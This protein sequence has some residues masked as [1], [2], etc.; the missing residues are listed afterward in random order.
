VQTQGEEVQKE[1]Q[2]TRKRGGQGWF[3]LCFVL[4]LFCL[5]LFASKQ[6]AASQ[7]SSDLLISDLRNPRFFLGLFLIISSDVRNLSSDL[8]MLISDLFLLF[9]RTQQGGKNPES[10]HFGDSFRAA[11]QTA[12]S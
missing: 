4:I 2:L 12:N 1:V 8:R 10:R 6:N 5:I 9:F 11:F 3:C 7:L